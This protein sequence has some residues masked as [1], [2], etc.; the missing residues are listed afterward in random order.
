M[1]PGPFAQNFQITVGHELIFQ[2]EITKN[3]PDV[4]IENGKILNSKS[5]PV[6]YPGQGVG[7]SF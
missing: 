5:E 2:G 6:L 1:N 4:L 7:S 3:P